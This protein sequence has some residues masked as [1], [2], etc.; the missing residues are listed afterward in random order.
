[1][2]YQLAI[3]FDISKDFKKAIE[4]YLKSIYKGE[5]L[6]DANINCIVIL[7][8]I[9]LDLNYTLKMENKYGTTKVE[10]DKYDEIRKKLIEDSK[11]KYYS[12]EILFWEY[13]HKYLSA[14]DIDRN[15]L[16]DI[17][18]IEKE[19]LTPYWF[20]Y[21]LDVSANRDVSGYIDKILILKRKISGHATIKNEYILG[22]LESVDYHKK[23]GY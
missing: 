14:S 5:N 10:F 4:F 3:K 23:L 20:L 6:I 21:F 11:R 22:E 8:L 17:I 9:C 13:Y 2:Y 19:N 1:M 15:E 16:L 7:G 12:N 18:N